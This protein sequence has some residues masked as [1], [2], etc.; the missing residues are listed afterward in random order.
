MGDAMSRGFKRDT[1]LTKRLRENGFLEDRRSFV[2]YDLEMIPH[3]VLFGMD[4]TTQRH[5][6]WAKSRGNCAICRRR[7]DSLAWEMDHIQG[8]LSGRCDC[9]HN[10]RALCVDCHRSRHVQV[11]FGA[12]RSQAIADFEKVN[13]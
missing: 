3:F 13:Q 9:S 1:K 2:G 11:K 6:V 10:L 4:L 5:L 7:L 12:S 8:G